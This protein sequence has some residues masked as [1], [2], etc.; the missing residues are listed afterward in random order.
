[1]T[2]ADQ[3]ES[4]LDGRLSKRLASPGQ[5][6]RRAGLRARVTKGT[7]QLIEPGNKVYAPEQGVS[8][9]R[10]IPCA[11]LQPTQAK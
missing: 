2:E 7:C 1:M 11:K 5:P 4:G 9:G 3:Q 10:L 8:A 6:G